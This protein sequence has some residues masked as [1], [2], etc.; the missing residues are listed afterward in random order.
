MQNPDELL[1]LAHE[2]FGIQAFRPGQEE[3][4]NAVLEGRDALAV[5]P[6]GYGKSA[7]YQIPAV[8]LAGPT[9]VI[10]PLIALQ[11]DQAEGLAGRDVGGAA[12]MNSSV[13][14][15]D[16]D[17]TF[18][19]LEGGR[20]EFIFLAPEQLKRPDVMDH[21]REAGPSLWVVDEAHCIS[22][23]GHD[24]R[25]DY[26]NIGPA[27]EA[28]GHPPV[29]ALT[30]TAAPQVREEIV[31]RL[32]M[33]DP[34]I[35]VRGFDRPN[36][37]LS[38][39]SFG[40]PEAKLARLIAAV[41]E[42]ER[43]GIVYVA[44]RRHAEE[45]AQHLGDRGM[46]ADFYHGGMPNAER[47]AVQERFMSGESRIIV[48]TSAFG[49]GVDKPDIR[50][51]YHYD[52]A[53]SPEAYYQEIGRAGR[54]GE[55]SEAVLFYRPAD[56]ALYKFFA[57]G[58]GIPADELEEV[59]ESLCA[60]GKPLARSALAERSGLS[61][62][63]LSRALHLLEDAGFAARHGTQEFA[64]SEADED[65]VHAAVQAALVAQRRRHQNALL[66]IESMRGYAE[67]LGCRR[68]YLLGYFGEEVPPCGRCD[69]CERGLPKAR[70]RADRP[71]ALKTRVLHKQF[72]KGL[73]EGYEGRHVIVFF[74]ELGRK[75]LD[76]DLIARGKLLKPI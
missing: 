53:D 32:Q 26:M 20:L 60:A 31:A 43:P 64:A 49:M 21:L 18:T 56:L 39:E 42:A 29:L 14:S 41:E 59:A 76:L 65:A 35:I 55:A 1:R 50:F 63:R 57:G 12:V 28:L 68:Q 5:M 61:A 71:F 52:I 13:G 36:I 16:R 44:T 69:N 54:D 75:V 40:K 46:A 58:G 34:K 15:G 6:T 25:P 7:I 47:N 3:M 67:L 66:K 10:S 74:E 37:R 62:N 23:W 24:F 17:E 73:V 72:G 48:A 22:E 45:V 4:I 8:M 11:R 27:V 51:V 19:E 38:V 33:R 9:V 30:A 70:P 2:R